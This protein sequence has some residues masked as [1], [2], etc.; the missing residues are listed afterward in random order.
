MSLN[1]LTAKDPL[2]M[3]DLSKKPCDVRADIYTHLIY[4]FAKAEIFQ[5][6]EMS[7][8]SM[9]LEHGLDRKIPIWC[10]AYSMYM[11]VSK[12]RGYPKMDGL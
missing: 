8:S 5:E 12:N 7:G 9:V 3:I 4:M 10:I 2:E 1:S 6:L 11:G